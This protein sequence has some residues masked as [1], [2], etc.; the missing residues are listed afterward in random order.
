MISAFGPIQKVGTKQSKPPGDFTDMHNPAS[1]YC[2]E[3]GY[4]LEIREGELGQYGICI[5]EPLECD[6]WDFFNGSCSLDLG[7]IDKIK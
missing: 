6:E 5:N 7:L 1:A 4:R 2:I 3:Q